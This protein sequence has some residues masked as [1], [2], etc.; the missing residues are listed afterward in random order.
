MKYPDTLKIE[1]TNYCDGNCVYC[2]NHLNKPKGYMD[3]KMF[4][5][6][7]D[8]FP[9]VKKITPQW[10]GESSLHPDFYE[11][12]RYAKK[13]G[14]SIRFYTNGASIDPYKLAKIG[15][16]EVRFSIEADNKELYEKL[17]R[18]LNWDV[19]YKNIMEFQKLKGATKVLV[20]MTVTEENRDR[21]HEIKAFWK[22]RVRNVTMYN[23]HSVCRE[24]EG[25]Y[26][27]VTSCKKPSELMIIGWNG[28]YVMCCTDYNRKITLGNVK[29]GA[30]KVWEDGAKMREQVE[31][32]KMLGICKE[33]GFTHT[34]YLTKVK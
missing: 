2:S 9:E 25:H 23:E 10:F 16:N 21:I 29:D 22:K 11:A 26:K 14:K 13:K 20:R 18:G 32:G 15:V 3:I 34:A 24:V 1:I 8:D 7:I 12:L 4:K 31:K 17:R 28:D 19:V 30:R 27:K 5:A 6:I 33:C